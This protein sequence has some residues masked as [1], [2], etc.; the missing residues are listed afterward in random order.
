MKKSFRCSVSIS[1]NKGIVRNKEYERKTQEKYIVCKLC[2]LKCKRTQAIV[3][4]SFNWINLKI[5]T[6]SESV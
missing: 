4:F 1:H 5:E 2:S 3:S 6:H